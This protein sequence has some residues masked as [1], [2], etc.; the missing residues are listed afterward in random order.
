MR[1]RLGHELELD[2][3]HDVPVLVAHEHVELARGTRA[4]SL[5]LASECASAGAA[6]KATAAAPARA[7]VGDSSAGR[8]VEGA[9]GVGSSLAMATLAGRSTP[10]ASHR[11]SATTAASAA[12]RR[13]ERDRSFAMSRSAARE[14]AS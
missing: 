9:A 8:T 5:A 12:A 13:I 7:R 6:S 11:T 1:R 3:R 2:L 10:C 4:R 14:C